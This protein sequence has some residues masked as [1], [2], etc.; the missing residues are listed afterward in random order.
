MGRLDLRIAT[1]H[2]HY[3]SGMRTPATL[4]AALREYIAAD[5]SFNVW[6]HVLSDAELAPYLNNLAN[7]KAR[8]LPLYGIPFAIKDNIDLAGV[9]TTAGCPEFAYTPQTSAFAV[10][11][12]IAAGAIP[13]GKT[14]LD[15]FATGLVGVRS[16]Y[17]ACK[18]AV[19]PQFIAGGSS[20]GSAVAVARRQV[21]FALGTDTAGSG[22][23]PAALNGIVGWKPSRGRVST[24]GV[25]PAC[26]SLDCVSTFSVSAA[27][28]TTLMGVLSVYDPG[29]RWSRR[30]AADT[31]IE[32]SAV[33]VVGVPLAHQ[34]FFFGA[35][36]S[37]ALFSTAIERAEQLGAQVIEVDIAPFLAAGTLLYRGPWVAERRLALTEVLRDLPAAVL[38]VIKD[39]LA[40][41]QSMTA[42][43]T[44]AGLHQLAQLRR[45]ADDVLDTIDALLLPT[46]GGT[47]TIDEI[48]ADPIALNSQLGHYTT[49]ANLLDLAAVALPAGQ[50]AA[51]LPFGISLLH[52][53]GCDAQLLRF[54]ARWC[55][56]SSTAEGHGVGSDS[57]ESQLDNSA[58][59]EPSPGWLDLIVCGA[60]MRGLPLNAQLVARH[61]EFVSA[62]RTAPVYRFYALPGAPA[63][64]GLVRVASGGASVEVEIWR[65]PE[66]EVGGLL[67]LIPSPLGLGKVQLHDGAWITGFICESTAVADAQDI[68]EFGSWR[69]FLASLE[70]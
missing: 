52:R 36:Y 55:G 6:I 5:A 57:I 38:P 59:T 67:A 66:V 70:T 48:A 61:G 23:V 50:S 69:A 65:L 13:M 33:K 17:G 47:F 31:R 64:P 32:R 12:L 28:A 53:A 68:T 20:S 9:P 16:P 2:A 14:N 43:E 41:A 29:D 46:T 58:K 22:R 26:A 35:A 51:G 7:A 56:E 62:T 25:V 60:H 39:I 40:P 3:R 24:S 54:A 49:F 1:L 30:R 42:M 19:L 10:Q 11:R 4:I 21:T 8:T 63:R 44:F 34:R 45:A 27:D 37:P 15:Q 18:N